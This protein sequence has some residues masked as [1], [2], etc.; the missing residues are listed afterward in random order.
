MCTGSDPVLCAYDC[1]VINVLKGEVRICKG[2]LALLTSAV[3]LL[4]PCG[5]LR[6]QASSNPKT[7]F[8]Q[9]ILN[10]KVFPQKTLESAFVPGWPNLLELRPDWDVLK[11]DEVKAVVKKTLPDGTEGVL[12]AT[13]SSF[14]SKHL[15]CVSTKKIL[16]L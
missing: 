7:Y 8:F 10:G 5:L 12:E 16:K 4:A 15:F 1:G 6:G 11:C 13:I 14:L 2:R 9:A 3:A